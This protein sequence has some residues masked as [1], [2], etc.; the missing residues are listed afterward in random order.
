MQLRR[1]AAPKIP[2]RAPART[3]TRRV[4]L[5]RV[6]S[7][8]VNSGVF[9]NAGN[10]KN[11]AN[12][13]PAAIDWSMACLP[14]N[15][16]AGSMRP[17]VGRRKAIGPTRFPLPR[18]KGSA[19]LFTMNAVTQSRRL[20]ITGSIVGLLALVAAVLTQWVLPAVFPP[21]PLE[22]VIVETGQ[23]VKDRLIA[24]AKRLES[25]PSEA[26]EQRTLSRTWSQALSIA[27]VSLG[28]LAIA[29]AVFSVIRRE[30][31]LTA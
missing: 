6:G 25:H 29:L 24:R 1:L 3:R 23:R 9:R 28:L 17:R 19:E 5:G 20:G 31:K 2:W 21:K 15:P 11:G 22:Q 10:R 18:W 4:Y 14:L 12:G 7:T 30:E 26:S 8:N 16:R 27:A 13:R